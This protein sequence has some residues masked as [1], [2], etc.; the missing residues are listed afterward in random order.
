[1]N[2]PSI[3]RR[4][5]RPLWIGLVVVGVY[6]S[7]LPNSNLPPALLPSL[8]L[9]HALA[10]EEAIGEEFARQIEPFLQTYC[11]D[12]HSGADPEAKFDT[13]IYQTP[14]QVTASWDSWKAIVAR[15][16][17]GEMPPAE[18]GVVPTSEER[19]MLAEWTGRFR[20]AEARRTQGDPGPVS[21]R[22]LS[23]AEWNYSIRDLTGVDIQPA[24]DFPVDPANEA[25]F[26]NSAE[27]LTMS[28][29]LV[30]KYLNAARKVSEHL[31]LTPEGIR[32]APFPVVT[33]TD[34]DKYCVQRIVDFYQR[35][36]TQ[37]A[38]YLVACYELQKGSQASP[39][40]AE[41]DTT[42][43]RLLLSE[44]YLRTVW[45]ALRGDAA[46]FGPLR[47]IQQ[48]FNRICETANVDRERAERR[49]SNG[50]RKD[51]RQ[52]AK[53]IAEE[54]KRFQPQFANLPSPP[55][56]NGGSQSLV[57]WKNRQMAAHR[58]SCRVT[59]VD[60]ADVDAVFNADELTQWNDAS[61]DL[62][63]HMLDDLQRFCGTFPD[64][65]YIQERGRAHIDAKEAE[66]E[67]K[68]RLLSAGFHSMMG[69]FRDDQPLYDLVLDEAGRKELDR[70][71]YELDFI[72]NVP[73]RQYSGFIWFERAES[74]FIN[75][76][77]F[78]FIRAEDRSAAEEATFNKFAEVYLDKVRR[79]AQNDTVIEAVEFHFRD[80]NRRLREMEKEL[81]EARPGQLEALLEFAGRAF[82]RQL[83]ADERSGWE[84]FYQVS[85]EQ[86]GF[87]HRSAMEDTLV[88]ILVSPNHLFRWDLQASET[89]A[90]PLN[91][92]ELASR[93]SYFLWSSTPDERLLALAA[94][95]KLTDE[96]V[97]RDEARRM[98]AD[99]RVRGMVKEFLGNWLDFRRFESHNGVDRNQFPQFND[100]L[101]QAMADEPIEFFSDLLARDGSLLELLDSQH[102]V[103]N[104]VLAEH[105]GLEFDSQRGDGW[106]RIA[107]Q[108]REDRGG[109]IPMA[110]FLT[111]NSP[112]LRTSP[113]K[114]GYWV[115]RKLLGETI[116][117]PPP[118]VPELPSS[119]HQ[120]GA[121]TL[122][123]VLAKHREHPSCASC[124][125][126]FD[127]F[128]LVLEGFDPIGRPRETDLAGRAVL[129]EAEMPNG[130]LTSGLSGLRDYISK[131]RLNDFRRHF[132]ESLLSYGLGR[133]LI[134]PDD[135]LVEEMM[136]ALKE[137]DDRV[138]PVIEVILNSPQFLQKRATSSGLLEATVP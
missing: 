80:T 44:S 79:T 110:V 16:E 73:F 30:N 89:A 133:T 118:G 39:G 94:A 45:L 69:Y 123:E 24:S 40:D 35:Q 18:A 86:A 50:V 7:T 23:N 122:R 60:Q 48:E 14:Q 103:V 17:S 104:Q 109:L 53:Q 92:V 98:L 62:R 121:L 26:D 54:R 112:G 116:P 117:P 20:Q 77:A 83:S 138:L 67:G 27:S 51:F 119:E 57:L 137:H 136:V 93:L 135:L 132:C 125:D 5:F 97:R 134:L 76:P 124:H 105:Y 127:A 61:V 29:A 6:P 74:S 41:F 38:D 55:G 43:E 25:G 101:R 47:N 56:M 13:S 100:V 131:H 15:V 107:L 12:C 85:F 36:P 8:F 129:V 72:A 106:H 21:I 82:R 19:S 70:L 49:T 96:G 28:P 42:A 71:W 108:G 95:D 81:E 87:D 90:V 99:P 126:R 111:Q 58:L 11:N 113:V 4:L 1:M 37:L 63:S 3:K 64:A 120:L 33:D 65:F 84:E 34:R 31:L 59:T 32:F 75:E 52:L 9:S 102:V 78:H 22:R 114:R 46:H 88:A 130:Q 128:G 91:N 68:G 10:N 115:V 2:W 66:R